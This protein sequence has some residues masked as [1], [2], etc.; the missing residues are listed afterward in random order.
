MR[1]KVRIVA[2]YVMLLV[3]CLQ[4]LGIL[5]SS[6]GRWPFLW[7][8]VVLALIVEMFG[9][10]TQDETSPTGSDSV[11]LRLMTLALAVCGPAN[12]IWTWASPPS[13]FTQV[14][15]SVGLVSTM[16][17]G[18]LTTVLLARGHLQGR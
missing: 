18:V 16:C 8:I 17:L 12:I 10:A 11:S 1:D 13:Q 15:A 14:L 2:R 6:P 5:L 7:A 3:C 4:A 9:S